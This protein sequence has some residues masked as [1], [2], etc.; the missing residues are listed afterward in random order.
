MTMIVVTHEMGFAREVADRVV[1]MD[2][3]VIVEQGTAGAGD[4]QPEGG[5]HQAVPR[6]RPGALRR[7]RPAVFLAP[8][9]VLL[10]L[11]GCGGSDSGGGGDGGTSANDPFYGVIS[12]E[13]LPDGPMLARLGQGGAGTL[14][15]NLAWGTVQSGPDAPYDWSHYDP[16][17]ANAAR[18]GVRV[19]ATVYSSPTWAEPTPET[20]PLGSSLPGFRSFARAAAERYGAGGTFWAANPDLP[21]L[22]ITDWQAWNEPNSPLFWK[23]DPN[24]AQYMTLLRAFRSAVKG[25]DPR[26]QILL[27]GLFPTPSGGISMDGSSASSTAPAVAAN[28]SRRRFIPMRAPR[29]SRSPASRNERR[30][31]ERFGDPD[32]P[33]WITEVGWASRGVPPGLVV[34]PAGQANYV[35]QTFELAAA[36]RDR[37][38]IAGVI[39]YS[40]KDTPGPDL[41]RAL[42][43]V[44][45]GRVAEAGVGGVRR[46]GRRQH[47]ELLELLRDPGRLAVEVPGAQHADRRRRSRSAASRCVHPPAALTAPGALGS[48]THFRACSKSG[49]S[50]LSSNRSR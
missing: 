40:L 22:P 17:I 19:L 32:M 2:D 25:A 43:A 13:P 28:S 49:V 1:F 45:A 41:G 37:L 33:I 4:R 30:I 9:V 10:A 34:G 24:A 36:Q 38:G 44:Q 15:I 48:I 8:L 29:E 50:G 23:P 16:V 26:A 47:P 12:A 18:A 7:M 5:A 3:G 39:W 21:E 11:A 27:G 31:T 6:A 20:P 46:G 14:R 35:T 42:R